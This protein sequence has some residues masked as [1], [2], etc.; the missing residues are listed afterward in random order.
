[1]RFNVNDHFDDVDRSVSSLE[2]DGQ[3]VR[4]VTLSRS[5][6]TTVDDLWDA[7]TNACHTSRSHGNSAET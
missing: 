3:P 6:A 2:R 4:A 7:V 1:M 5:Y